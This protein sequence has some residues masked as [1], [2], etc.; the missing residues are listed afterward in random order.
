LLSPF[1]P[2]SQVSSQVLTTN[3]PIK[4]IF[5]CPPSPAAE[6]QKIPISRRQ[7]FGLNASA[8]I[9]PNAVGYLYVEDLRKIAAEY[10]RDYGLEPAT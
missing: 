2:S 10:I 8:N 7:L 4:D 5:P 6:A 3:C 1:F 9:N